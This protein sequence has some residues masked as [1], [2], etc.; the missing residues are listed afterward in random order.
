MQGKENI[1]NFTIGITVRSESNL[2]VPIVSCGTFVFPSS[3][4]LNEIFLNMVLREAYL[5]A[6]NKLDDQLR[7]MCGEGMNEDN[8]NSKDAEFCRK[9]TESVFKDCMLNGAKTKNIFH[10]LNNIIL[11]C[12]GLIASTVTQFELIFD[13]EESRRGLI[14]TMIEQI[15]AGLAKYEFDEKES[16]DEASANIDD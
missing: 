15:T 5:S 2:E 8:T 6:K 1:Y 14:K 10:L 3:S 11:I 16:K 13:N 7:L 9:I 4:P 12:G